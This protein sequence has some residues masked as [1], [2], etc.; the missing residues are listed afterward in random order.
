MARKRELTRKTN[1]WSNCSTRALRPTQPLSTGETSPTVSPARASTKTRSSARIGSLKRWRHY[2]LNSKEDRSWSVDENKRLLA[3][4]S[5]H[6]NKWKHIATLLPGRTGGQVKN[7]FFNII[8]T[9]LR[10]AFKMS[11][12]RSDS[13]VVSEIKPKVISDIVNR[14]VGQ[15][16]PREDQTPDSRSIKDF[17]LELVNGGCSGDAEFFRARE[18]LINIKR[19]MKDTKWA[20]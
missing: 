18:V 5:I 12:K 13:L 3:L 2:L 16:A 14:T 19:L 10:K 17:L 11:F 20:Y 7:Q 1:S 15:I 9:L 4:H 6:L 8:R